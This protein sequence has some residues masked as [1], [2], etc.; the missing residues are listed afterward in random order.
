MERLP[1]LGRS[2]ASLIKESYH[3]PFHV[4]TDRPFGGLGLRFGGP[5]GTSGHHDLRHAAIHHNDHRCSAASGPEYDHDSPQDDDLLSDLHNWEL[6][7]NWVH[8]SSVVAR[9]D[10]MDREHVKGAVDNAKGAVKDA[11]GKVTGDKKLQAEG[12]MDKAKGAA[13]NAAGDIKDATR[14]A[15]NSQPG[16]GSGS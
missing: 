11:A 14:S 5:Y 13:H 4:C 10:I 16:S 2:S 8:S 3:A 15:I 9:G 6:W 7:L 12:K 1:K